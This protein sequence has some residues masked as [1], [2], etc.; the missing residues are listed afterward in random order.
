MICI[1]KT[2]VEPNGSTYFC[3]KLKI[4]VHAYHSPLAFGCRLF[5]P[6]PRN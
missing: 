6:R 1:E 3:P 2:Q 4:V 5:A